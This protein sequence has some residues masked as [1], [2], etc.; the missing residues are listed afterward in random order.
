M[1]QIQ[2]IKN[3]DI[4]YI[5]SYVRERNISNI[6]RF[7]LKYTK[8]NL[9]FPI[10]LN[11][12]I[13]YLTN[14]LDISNKETRYLIPEIN[15]EKT[16][17]QFC[18]EINNI[19]WDIERDIRKKI[20]F[21]NPIKFSIKFSELDDKF[22][23]ESHLASTFIEAYYL[24]KFENSSKK[25]SYP[26]ALVK[27][28]VNNNQIEYRSDIDFEIILS[29]NEKYY[30]INPNELK[31]KSNGYDL[32]LILYH[33][34]I[35]GL[36]IKS[37][38]ISYPKYLESY[39]NVN[40]SDFTTYTGDNSYLMIL[41]EPTVYDSYL[42]NKAI[43][44]YSIADEMLPMVEKFPE[45]TEKIGKDQKQN[46]F[47]FSRI[48]SEVV[49][50]NTTV[51][52]KAHNAYDMVTNEGLFF[53]GKLYD[54]PL[55]VVE[56]DFVTGVSI[57]HT[58]HYNNEIEGDKVLLDW[59]ISK[60]TLLTEAKDIMGPEIMDMLNTIGWSTINEDH[61]PNDNYTVGNPDNIFSLV[62]SDSSAF[63][64]PLLPLFNICIILLLFLWH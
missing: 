61:S 30:I 22:E 16:K 31:D 34:I 51:L 33:E 55:H 47:S 8:F 48:M 10:N 44:D 11:K 5:K 62:K 53:K 41:F 56:H 42:Y 17:K 15:C 9:Q 27:Q 29:N 35:H 19:I 50:T 49:E 40:S 52:N 24:L 32:R 46:L 57:T 1:V 64:I 25:L 37:E 54:I 28:L 2:N 60:G 39:E 4:T 63:S 38:A 6:G 26:Q 20:V 23:S 58:K 13:K 45:I 14:S 18:N 12:D 36:G 43:S 59:C 7:E 21:Y 3:E